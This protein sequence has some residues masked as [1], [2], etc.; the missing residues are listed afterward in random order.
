MPGINTLVRAL[1]A[2]RCAL[3]ASGTAAKHSLMTLD[4]DVLRMICDEIHIDDKN[5]RCKSLQSL[6]ATNR[7]MRNMAAPLLLRHIQ[8]RPHVEHL[9]G[10]RVVA[11]PSPIG[12]FTDLAEWLQVANTVQDF[13]K[14]QAL[15]S[16]T[17]SFR[18]NVWVAK[19]NSWIARPPQRLPRMLADVLLGCSKLEVLVLTIPE[20]QTS[21][22]AT[23]F[24]SANVT[25]PSVKT[26]LLSPHM[27]F[28][29]EMCP[30]VESISTSG[31]PWN[32]RCIDSECNGHYSIGLIEAASRMPRLRHFEMLEDWNKS[33]L[34]TVLYNMP[35]LTSL[36]MSSMTGRYSNGIE[37]LLPT[38]KMFKA[39]ETLAL[40]DV[41]S[42][43][44]GISPGG[45]G[46]M[47]RGA[48]GAER[49]LQDQRKRREATIEVAKMVFPACAG[50]KELWVGD[51]SKAV[52]SRDHGDDLD[53]E[54]V[55]VPERRYKAFR[56]DRE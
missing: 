2:A 56:G 54:W 48:A 43:G 3:S 40:A 12:W 33:L 30:N 49:R 9:F 42:L 29:V 17:R 25:L 34:R 24:Y 27:E 50:L 4:D 41:A 10:I 51:W 7:R 6:S 35:N 36:A 1:N 45:C 44:V 22:F 39:L 20:H 46:N 18:L 37:S 11:L 38:L 16:H 55:V 8:I 32:H 14:C 52:V 15:S 13:S 47:Y 31:Y 19:Q 28:V 53:I 26:L 21:G 5:N 23:A